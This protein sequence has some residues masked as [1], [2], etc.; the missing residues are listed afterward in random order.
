VTIVVGFA[1][2]GR[3]RGPLHLAAMIARTTGEE[4]V[5]GA[6]VPVPWPPGVARVDAEYQD[7]LVHSAEEALTQARAR[8]PA[9]V[10]A[11]F[12]VHHARSAPAGL[13]ELADE[14]EATAIVVGSSAAGVLGHVWL[15]SASDRLLHSS[16]IPVVLTPSG[17]RCKPGHRVTRISAAFGG[18]QRTEEL[19]VAAAGVA[20][21]TGAALRVV[22]FVVRPPAP[23]TAGVGLHAEDPVVLEWVAEIEGTAR[24]ALEEVEGL[25][26]HPPALEAAV[27][28]GETWAEALEDVEW[29]DGDVLVVGSSAIGPVRRVFLGSRASK[30]VRHSPVPVVVVPRSAAEELAEEAVQAGPRGA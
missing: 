30:I 16:H 7:W 11:S 1:P 29:D 6:V 10:E 27:G 26:A 17:F 24:K 13:L 18:T 21:R 4:V 5:V 19:V 12:T 28:H 2:D 9:D 15:G 14:H 3:S 22:S 20:A 23:V 25:A 8:M